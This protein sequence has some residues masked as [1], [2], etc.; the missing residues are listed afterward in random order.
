MFKRILLLFFLGIL[1]SSNHR[2]YAF[3]DDTFTFKNSDGDIITIKKSQSYCKPKE[4]ITSFISDAVI[5]AEKL[6]ISGKELTPFLL[7]AVE[8][9][10]KGESLRANI[11]L[12]KNNISLGAK[13]A[14][15]VALCVNMARKDLWNT[16]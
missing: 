10:S 14:K 5:E 12:A 2:T 8:Q 9:N 1:F 3:W 16:S 11:S 4:K 15:E 13:I 7:K 6:E